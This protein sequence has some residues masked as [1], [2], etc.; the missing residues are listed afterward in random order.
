MSGRYERKKPKK[1]KKS[2]WKIA[3]I[4]VAVIVLVLAAIAG[5]GYLYYNSLLNKINR[6]EVIDKGEVSQDLQNQIG[7]IVEGTETE[8]TMPKETEPTVT[9][10]TEPETVPPM[11]PED[12]VNILVIGQAARPG[13]EARM[14]DS[15]ILVTLNKYDKTVYL[16]SIL[17]DAFVKYPKYKT[18]SEGRCKFTSAYAN[19]YARWGGGG[20]FEVMNLLLNQNFGVNVDYDLEIGFDSVMNFVDVLGSVEIE[21]TDEEREYM[22]KELGEG[23]SVDPKYDNPDG[24][25]SM[26]GYMTLVFARMRKAKGDNESDIKR[27]ARQR[28]LVE[29]ILDKVKYKVATEGPSVLNDLADAV[30]PSLTTNMTNS[31]ITKLIMDVVPILMDLKIDQGTLPVQGT[32]KGEMYDIY[33]DGTLH[34]ILRFDAGQNIKLVTPITEGSFASQP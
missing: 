1:A 27:T 15:A 12:I 25:I 10:T 30:L 28:Y 11:K 16:H 23:Y 24:T 29:R 31:E 33:S 5:A 17:R 14:A 13:E 21:M 19:A 32:Y 7:A 18:G 2:G 22:A 6:A 9:E 20:A 26:D 4:V 8:W 34:S 3:L